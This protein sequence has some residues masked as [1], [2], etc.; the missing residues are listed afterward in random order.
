MFV[1]P[2]DDSR[3]FHG[4]FREELANVPL[5]HFHHE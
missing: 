4:F 2:V 5:L 1:Q 3:H